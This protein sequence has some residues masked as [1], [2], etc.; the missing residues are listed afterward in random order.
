MVTNAFGDFH[1]V[2][3]QTLL[4]SSPVLQ[5]LVIILLYYCLIGFRLDSIGC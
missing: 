5:I 4:K 3:D 1:T 2:N